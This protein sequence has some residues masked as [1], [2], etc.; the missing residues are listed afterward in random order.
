MKGKT[1]EIKLDP[2]EVRIV[3]SN[4]GAFITIVLEKGIFKIYAES[5]RVSV[6]PVSTTSVEILLEK[7][8]E[9]IIFLPR[10]KTPKVY[11]NKM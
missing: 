1:R 8:K 10:T 4:T 6:K 7:F 2:G 9:N 11:R 5:G 3:E